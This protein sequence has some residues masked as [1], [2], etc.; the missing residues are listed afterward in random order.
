MWL[1]LIIDYKGSKPEPLPNLDLKIE[2]GDS[3]LTQNVKIEF[4][5]LFASQAIEELKYLKDKFQN[6]FD[7]TEKEIFLNKINKIKNDLKENYDNKKDNFK[8]QF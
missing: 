5:G 3:L 1:S 4:S 6:S 2:T 8:N 7:K